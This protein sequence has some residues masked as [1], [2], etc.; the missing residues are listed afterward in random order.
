MKTQTTPLS[1]Q[2][3]RIRWQT[4]LSTSTARLIAELAYGS[5][6]EALLD[7]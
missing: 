3:K 6:Y 2:S 5:Q 1:R 4:G 7:G